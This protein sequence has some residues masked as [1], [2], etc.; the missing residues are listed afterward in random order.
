MPKKR[1]LTEK[2]DETLKKCLHVPGA[3]ERAVHEIWNLCHGKESSC[4]RRTFQNVVNELLQEFSSMAVLEDLVCKN[5]AKLTIPIMNVQAFVQ[6]LCQKSTALADALQRSLSA[7]MA[8]TPV[9]YLDECTAGNVV[10]VEQDRKCTLMYLSWLE[11]WHHLKNPNA[12]LPIAAVQAKCI[13]DSRFW[14]F[15]S[16]GCRF[17]TQSYKRECRRFQCD[18]AFWKDFLHEAKARR[19]FFGR[20][21]CHPSSV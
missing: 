15:C 8:L 14:K 11:L 20:Q 9:I 4:S 17:E 5:G 13:E 16:H 19:I 21:R 10:G 12:W 6:F 3:S 7:N 2:D 18:A 1:K